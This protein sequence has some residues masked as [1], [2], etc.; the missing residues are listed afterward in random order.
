MRGWLFL[1][2]HPV[3]VDLI[4]SDV[5]GRGSERERARGGGRWGNE[6]KMNHLND[7]EENKMEWMNECEKGGSVEEENKERM[8]EAEESKRK[9]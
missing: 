2:V 9:Q 8:E 6:G 4:S 7:K 3:S 1:P 5:T